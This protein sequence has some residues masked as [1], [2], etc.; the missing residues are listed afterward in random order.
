MAAVQTC[1]KDKPTCNIDQFCP[2]LDSNQ[3]PCLP[4]TDNIIL[5]QGCYCKA[6]QVNVNCKE[7]NGGTC[8]RCLKGSYYSDSRCKL[9]PKGC[10]HCFQ[11]QSCIQ[12]ADNYVLNALTQQCE[13]SCESNK[14][15]QDINYRICNG[16]TKSCSACPPGCQLCSSVEICNACDSMNKTTTLGGLCTPKCDN[17][18]D[19][20]Y[21]KKGVATICGEG[22]DSACKCGGSLNCATCTVDNKKCAT[23][24]PG[25]EKNLTDQ[26]QTCS[27]G[28]EKLGDLCWKLEEVESNKIG[29]GAI[30]GIVIGIVAVVGVV[31]CGVAY[32]L[33]RRA[34]KLLV[35]EAQ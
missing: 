8:A 25:I 30:A 32:Y 12:C 16:Q 7:C 19:G 27:N 10:I 1:S 5:G 4:C 3:V 29:S 22:I 23:C 26:C 15:C 11:E 9:C 35:S 14:D 24:L 28:Y 6:G 17:L 18:Q 13:M 31:G 33:V 34:K 20:Q 2:A 21:C